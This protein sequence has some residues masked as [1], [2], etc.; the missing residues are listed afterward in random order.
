MATTDGQQ[1]AEPKC[2]ACGKPFARGEIR[3]RRGLIAVHVE[4]SRWRPVAV[5]RRSVGRGRI[6]TREPAVT[7]TYV[8][9]LTLRSAAGLDDEA[10]IGLFRV[11]ARRTHCA[12]TEVKPNGLVVEAAP[13]SLPALEQSLRELIREAG[14]HVDLIT[15]ARI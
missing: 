12:P 2:A 5:T 10:L 7:S 8:V 13:E 15:V 1:P 4:C 9:S 6:G 14:G 3:V 11:A